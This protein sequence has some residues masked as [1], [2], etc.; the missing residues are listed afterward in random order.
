[1][2]EQ[3]LDA[4]AVRLCYE[5]LGEECNP[6]VVLIMGLNLQMVWWSDDLVQ[7]LLDRDLRVVR[8]DNRD[9]GLSSTLPG[10]PISVTQFLRRRAQAGYGLADMADDTAAIIDHVAPHG[11]HVVGASLGSFVA[12][13]TAI[14][15][16]SKVLSLTSIMGRTG[17]RRN[18]KVAWSMRAGFLRR[19]PASLEAQQEQMV[20]VFHKMGSTGRTAQD[21]EDVRVA[22]RRSHARN[23]GG[24]S[25]QLAAV[26]NERDRTADLR[27]LTLPALVIHGDRDKVVLPSGGRATADAIAGSELMMV[28]GMG[29]DLPRRLWPQLVDGIARTVQRSVTA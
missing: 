12:Q 17:D 29:H 23:R 3:Q 18:G 22:I 8:F 10:H 7:L 25:G 2:G 15:H 14:R 11:A 9:T 21:D 26:L 28:A 5:V 13:E 27:A 6:T 1:M 4:G 20:R 16:P 19:T 24:G